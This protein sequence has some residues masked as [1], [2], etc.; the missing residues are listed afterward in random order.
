MVHYIHYKRNSN[1]TAKNGAILNP[2]IEFVNQCCSWLILDEGKGSQLSP[3]GPL[4]SSEKNEQL[5]ASLFKTS[6]PFCGLFTTL[7]N[8]SNQYPSL[9]RSV[10]KTIQSLTDQEAI[11][12]QLGEVQKIC[13]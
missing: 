12:Q 8:A 5:A 13:C 1:A 6:I 3:K 7:I 11:L 2:L 10:L 9:L 4:Q